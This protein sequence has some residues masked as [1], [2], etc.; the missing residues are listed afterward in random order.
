MPEI[1]IKECSLVIKHGT[2]SVTAKH[3]REIN[4][5]D[6]FKPGC[7]LMGGSVPVHHSLL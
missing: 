6:I 5:V 2:H 1:K 7:G 3:L 4:E